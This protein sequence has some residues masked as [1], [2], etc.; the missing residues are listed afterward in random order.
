MKPN[1]KIAVTG[2]TG[3]SGRYDLEAPAGFKNPFWIQLQGIWLLYATP[4]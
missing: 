2:G 3:K 4:L 1:I